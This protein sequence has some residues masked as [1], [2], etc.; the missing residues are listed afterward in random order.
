MLTHT[1]TLL[2]GYQRAHLRVG[3]ERIAERVRLRDCGCDRLGLAE[4]LAGNEQA[5][6]RDTGL[7]RVEQAAG[8]TRRD[9]LLQVGIFQDDAGRL[10][11]Q[12]EGGG[13]EVVPGHLADVAAD[14]L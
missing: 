8:D 3:V 14:P 2:C 7:A 6:E 5:A 1:L 9:C 12:L 10:A 4:Q 13:H 11:S